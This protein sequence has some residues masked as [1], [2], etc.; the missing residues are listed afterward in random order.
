MQNFNKRKLGFVLLAVGTLIPVT[1]GY[2]NFTASPTSIGDTTKKEDT[3]ANAL[4]AAM[5]TAEQDH[6][7]KQMALNVEPSQVE[8]RIAKSNGGRKISTVEVQADLSSD[9]AETARAVTPAPEE[10]DFDMEDAPTE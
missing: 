7:Q 3:M 1:L 9:T 6:L 8:A 2:Q 5:Q 10:D 4:Q